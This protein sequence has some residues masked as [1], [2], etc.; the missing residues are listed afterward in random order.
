MRR[1]RL[2]IIK[3]V[4]LFALTV[5][6]L[7]GTFTIFS[8]AANDYSSLPGYLGDGVPPFIYYAAGQNPQGRASSLWQADQT[9]LEWQHIAFSLFGCGSV[10]N[11]PWHMVPFST[12]EIFREC[13]NYYN[14]DLRRLGYADLA[15]CTTRVPIVSSRNF[16]SYVS[17]YY[18]NDDPDDPRNGFFLV[19]FRVKN[20]SGWT[21][22][23]LPVYNV[24]FEFI[25][26]MGAGSIWDYPFIPDYP[27]SVGALPSDC[28]IQQLVLDYYAT[29]YNTFTAIDV[30]AVV[31]QYHAYEDTGLSDANNHKRPY[32]IRITV[33]EWFYN[34]NDIGYPPLTS[35]PGTADY[36]NNLYDTEY[37]QPLTSFG[38]NRYIQTADMLEKRQFD[39]G[40]ELGIKI[41]GQSEYQRGLSD[42]REQ[43]YD[44]GRQDGIK[45]TENYNAVDGI[46]TLAQVPGVFISGMLDFDFF[47]VNLAN[48]VKVVF[49]VLVVAFLIV[50]ILRFLL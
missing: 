41:G 48:A 29:D 14:A 3:M 21:Y 34:N 12:G 2:K 9:Q 6:T 16:T 26:N 24:W 10:E 37:A 43:G 42:G 15:N 45:A 1:K 44:K 4:V 5:S 28:V 38:F 31:G 50:L 36:F 17:T 30:G 33:E 40:F 18:N 49:T 47:G 11:D 25:N 19:Q 27:T 35:S 23:W 46:L 20:V 8:S 7:L 32:G 39:M 13:V 22:D